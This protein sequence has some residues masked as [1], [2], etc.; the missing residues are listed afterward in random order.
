MTMGLDKSDIVYQTATPAGGVVAAVR[1]L[2]ALLAAA[3][4]VSVPVGA[5]AKEVK[6]PFAPGEKLTF[7]LRWAFIPV[8]TATLEVLPIKNI[9]NTPAYHFQMTARTNAFADV[10][11]KVRDRID[12][13]AD[14]SMNHSVHFRKTQREGHVSRN[15]VVAF[16]WA[17]KKAYYHETID[18]Q[19]RT[20]DLIPGAFDPLSAFYYVRHTSLTD[21]TQLERPVTDGKKCV[22]GRAK[23]IRRETIRTRSGTYDTY[24]LEPELNHVK[25]VFE[26]SKNARLKIWV[27]ADHRMILVKV[28]SKVIVGSFIAELASAVGTTE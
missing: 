8:G 24:L 16:D 22:W 27:T 3:L 6:T 14:L 7:E 18:N 11:F 20:T 10:F 25:G 5:R 1:M 15:E 19:R 13:F 4:V 23:V 12:A 17:K 21:N 9:D 28:A 2:M 26:K